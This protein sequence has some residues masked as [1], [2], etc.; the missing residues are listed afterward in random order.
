MTDRVHKPTRPPASKL[1]SAIQFLRRLDIPTS[2]LAAL[3]GESADN[4]R[5]IDS[6]SYKTKATL[7]L[8]AGVND[9]ANIYL[10]DPEQWARLRGNQ[11]SD[12]YGQSKKRLEALAAKI[13]DIRALYQ[14]DLPAGYRELK[15]LLSQI[16][17]AKRM[18]ALRVKSLLEE[19]LG[20]FA[21]HLG[22]AHSAYAHAHSAMRNRRQCYDDSLGD[23]EHL[24][25]YA[26]A[27]LI[28]SNA[29][30]L[31]HKAA[32]AM[33]ILDFAYRAKQAAGERLG[34]EWY[35]QLATALLQHK[36]Y[37]SLATKLYDK[38]GEEMRR[39]GE[40][41]NPLSI[42][43]NRD[44]QRSLL[45]PVKSLEQSLELIKQAQVV[46]GQYS[47]EHVMAINWSAASAFMLDSN[48]AIQNAQE[49]LQDISTKVLPFEH[50]QTVSKLLLI[51]PALPL[52]KQ[53]KDAW[54]RFALYE[55]AASDK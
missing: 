43:M 14:N 5:H 52:S 13:E 1:K 19:N 40:Y 39:R 26:R 12:L 51:T 25:A 33:L 29:L 47:L 37:D 38:A 23:K 31:S 3:L 30:L 36:V 42:R 2:R 8:P 11:Q 28:A 41:S 18:E 46:F 53:A 54:L 10:D 20:W 22:L 27:G 45:N 35:R 55:N 49:L 9:L 34:S 24:I 6:R 4:I 32:E 16:V 48:I 17:S 44:R 21:V 15:R 7:P 50:Q